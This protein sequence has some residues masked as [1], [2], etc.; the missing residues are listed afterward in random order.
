MAMVIS[1]EARSATMPDNGAGQ[2]CGDDKGCGKER[3]MDRSVRV[4]NSGCS[5]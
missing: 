4:N 1:S 3:S 5:E 2:E